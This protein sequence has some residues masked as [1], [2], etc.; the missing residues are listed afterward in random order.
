[1]SQSQTI[2]GAAADKPTDF[3]PRCS[4]AALLTHRLQGCTPG[5]HLAKHRVE[6]LLM[7]RSGLEIIEVLE[8]GVRIQREL[9]LD[10][11]GMAELKGG[12]VKIN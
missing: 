8:V 5:H 2:T 6:H 4:H 10:G 11:G 3:R 12:M 1:M 9:G 7:V